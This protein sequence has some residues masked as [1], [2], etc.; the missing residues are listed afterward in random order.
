MNWNDGLRKINEVLAARGY[1][2]LGYD[3]SEQQKETLEPWF[4]PK[5]K[6][7]GLPAEVGQFLNHVKEKY[8]LAAS[9]KFKVTGQ[10]NTDIICGIKADGLSV[11]DIQNKLRELEDTFHKV[12]KEKFPKGT[13]KIAN[14]K[15]FYVS[16]TLGCI[17]E[18]G[19]DTDMVETIRSCWR[20]QKLKKPTPRDMYSTRPYIIDLANQQIFSHKGI[21]L[22]TN[23]PGPTNLAR[24]IFG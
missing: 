3:H 17:Y 12:D 15:A 21:P 4:Y 19:L 5:K 1:N 7:Q 6:G 13:V 23:A 9:R 14:K 11:V 16:L 20:K 10:Q 18:N 24:E 2:I 8:P 22:K